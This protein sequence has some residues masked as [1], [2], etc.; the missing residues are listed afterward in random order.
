MGCGPSKEDRDMAA[1]NEEIENQLKKDRMAQRNEIK[2]LLLGAGESG[3]ST[4]LKQFK[5]INQGAYS[6]EERDSYREIV[7]S[8]TLQS[9]R[10]VLDAM[11][12]LDIPLADGNNATRAEI[13]LSLPS[14]VEP[15]NLPRSVAEAIYGLWQDA[16]VRECVARSREYQLNDSAR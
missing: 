15:E 6:I 3:K 4:V 12:N 16:G 7:F 1:R 2:M 11:E 5:L 14:Q 13:I 10:V 8:N 9:M